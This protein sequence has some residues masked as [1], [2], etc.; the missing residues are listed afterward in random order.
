VG[1][2]ERDGNMSSSEGG[3]AWKR[4]GVKIGVGTALVMPDAEVDGLPAFLAM[5]KTHSALTTTHRLHLARVSSRTHRIF[6]PW[7]RSHAVRFTALID[8]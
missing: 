1:G 3:N 2:F 8:S 4:V 5:P 6:W 7:Q